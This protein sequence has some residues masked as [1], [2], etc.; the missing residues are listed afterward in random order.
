MCPDEGKLFYKVH[1]I[2]VCQSL[3]EAIRQYWSSANQLRYR[4]LLYAQVLILHMHGELR[5][6]NFPTLFT[7]WYNG[8]TNTL[9]IS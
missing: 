9:R 5:L 1:R 6:I 2:G 3:D 7:Y 8:I 4:L